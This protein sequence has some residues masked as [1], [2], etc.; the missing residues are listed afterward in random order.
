MRIGKNT[1]MFL[2][3][4]GLTLAGAAIIGRLFFIQVVSH[5][6]YAELALRQGTVV[7][8]SGTPRGRIYFSDADGTRLPAANT[9]SGHLLYID[10]RKVTDAAALYE[11]LEPFLKMTRDEFLSKAAKSADPFEAVAHKLDA[12]DI[13]QVNLLGEAAAGIAPE[14]WRFYPLGA[15]ASHVLGFVGF[16]GDAIVGRYGIERS[17]ESVLTGSSSSDRGISGALFNWG[18]ALFRASPARPDVV[19]TIEPEVQ[20]T[21]EKELDALTEK[22][23][24]ERAGIIVMDPQTGKILAMAA[25]PNFDPNA[26]GAAP[27]LDVFTNPTIESVYELGSVFKPLTLAAAIDSGKITPE[28][29]YDDRGYV[30]IGGERIE[31]FDGKGRGVVSMQTVLSESLNTGAV[32]VERT[33]GGLKL[34]DYFE[35]LGLADRTEVELPGEVLGKLE[36]LDSGSEF[37]YAAASFGQGVAV[38]PLAFLRA[39]SVLANGGALV[40]PY[41]IDRITV[42]GGPDAETRPV[43]QLNILKPKTAETVTRMLVRVVDEALLDGALKNE[44]YSIAAKT[45]TAQIASPSGGYSDDYLHAFVGYGP[46]YDAKFAVFLFM[47][48]P[49]GER[50]AART[51]SRP[52]MNIMDFL[53]SY[54]RVPPDR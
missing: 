54:Y 19:L 15:V 46:A 17:Q 24:P 37:D 23:K 5:S 50:Y 2:V 53:L 9:K 12:A 4:G 29:T 38:T 18:R 25:R 33:I 3:A 22:W 40:K 41:I 39:I 42:E 11:S 34:R 26:Y 47:L 44:H 14:E 36:N 10:P 28:T 21:I 43:I 32:F 52:F 31:N 8:D 51:L 6:Y 48:K 49:T 1:R 7:A 16:D 27:S 20:L 35:N 30:E 45:G 13:E